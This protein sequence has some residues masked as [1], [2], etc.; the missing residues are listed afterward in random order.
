MNLDFANSVLDLIM[1]TVSAPYD[2]LKR[3]VFSVEFLGNLSVGFLWISTVLL[4]VFQTHKQCIPLRHLVLF[5]V[6]VFLMAEILSSCF[7]LRQQQITSKPDLTNGHFF[8]VFSNSTTVIVFEETDHSV[9]SIRDFHSITQ[10]RADTS[11]SI[12][13]VPM[14]IHVVTS[15]YGMNSAHI[16]N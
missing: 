13:S 7:S 15:P 14:S 4:I 10:V 6:V 11:V 8:F 5:G 9:W 12:Y 1:L 2:L 3:I 16:L